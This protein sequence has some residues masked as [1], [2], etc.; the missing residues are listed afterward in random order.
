MH[1]YV[2]VPLIACLGACAM[3]SAVIARDPAARRSRIAAAI[4]A[5]AAIWGLCDLLAHVLKSEALALSLARIS[6]LPVHALPPLALQLLLE[7]SVSQRRRYARY[8][9]LI[10]VGVVCLS[11][12][13]FV[14][15]VLISG[16]VWTHWGWMTQL[17]PLCYLGFVPGTVCALTAFHF[18][19]TQSRMMTRV[20]PRGG[21]FLALMTMLLLSLFRT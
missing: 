8:L 14:S 16:I 20:E 4:L 2:L 18:F 13:N 12:A 7:E 11:L 17:G 9:V 6:M 1:L 5:C 15:P 21:R 3:T 19:R 10:W